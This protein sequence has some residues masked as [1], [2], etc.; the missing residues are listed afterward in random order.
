LRAE[1]L[2]EYGDPIRRFTVTSF[3]RLGGAWV[4]RGM[5]MAFVPPGQS[6]PAQEKSRLEIYTGD[7]DARLPAEWFEEAKFR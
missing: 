7:Y 3:R 1:A 4:P 6:L 5:E 2:N